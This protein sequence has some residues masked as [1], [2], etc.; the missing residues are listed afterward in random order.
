M[1][2]NCDTVLREFA[3]LRICGWDENCDDCN[4]TCV[5]PDEEPPTPICR[6]DDQR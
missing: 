6:E 5:Q 3:S 1:C 4:Q 2:R